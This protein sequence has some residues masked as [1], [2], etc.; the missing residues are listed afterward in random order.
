MADFSSLGRAGE[1]REEA[2][3]LSQGG[4]WSARLVHAGTGEAFPEAGIRNP[5]AKTETNA[6]MQPRPAGLSYALRAT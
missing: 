2:R 1:A 3:G 6:Y 5:P 4:A